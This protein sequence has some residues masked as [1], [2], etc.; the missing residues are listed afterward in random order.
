MFTSVRAKIFGMALLPLM[1][2]LFFMLSAVWEKYQVSSEMDDHDKIAH[3]IINFGGVLHEIQKERGTSG[4]YLTSKGKK[5]A[6]KMDGQR[7]QTDIA[8]EKFKSIISDFDISTLS[9]EAQTSYSHVGPALAELDTLRNNVTAQSVSPAE[10]LSQYSEIN[11]ELIHMVRDVVNIGGNSL[12][13]KT[14]AGY[15]YFIEGKERAGIE[16][17]LLA[18]TFT[19]DKFTGGVYGKF[20]GI[21]SKQDVY[22]QIFHDAATDKQ[23]EVYSNFLIQPDVLATQKLRDI[24]VTKGLSES[25]EAK[26][27]GVEASVWFDAISGKIELLK[28]MEDKIAESLVATSSN[29]KS[30]AFR[31]LFIMLG[32][33]VL[34]TALVSIAVFIIAQGIVLP[35]DHA[36]KMASEVS[37]GNLKGTLENDSRD[38]V[39]HLSRAMNTMVSDLGTTIASVNLVTDELSGSA[40][41]MSSIAEQTLAG[42]VQQQDELQAISIAVSQINNSVSHVSENATTA[43]SAT[44]EANSEVN[45]GLQIVGTTTESI[46]SLAAQIAKITSVIQKLESE[47]S[48]IETVLD[49]IG[50]IA[51][52]TNLLALNAAI[53]AARAGE[54]GRGFAVVADE[55]RTLAGRTQQATQEIQV[56]ISGLQTGAVAA[57]SAME[58]GSQITRQSVEQANSACESL[59]TIASAMTTVVE[60]NEKIATVTEQQKSTMG[61]I[62]QKI[63]S[64]FE[65][66]SDTAR[67]AA[68]SDDSSSK[69]LERAISLKQQ[70]S[71]FSH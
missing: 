8:L 59:N 62:D 49:V 41:E 56:M 43:S 50:S 69:L 14:R 51:E 44:H 12:M 47:T 20:I 21:I 11:E 40:S 24:A 67:G 25:A 36:V 58:Q 63:T 17:A 65:V 71:K 23:K 34:L 6:T 66:A 31:D 30:T 42:V 54:Q 32:L 64:I 60:M 39:G 35:L 52:Q 19:Q 27:L 33:A 22:F 57:V 68:H 28:S 10:S 53:E 18:S 26:G 37:D 38:E 1:T 9:T 15:Y 4:V 55:V 13:N 2:A 3:F 29:L 70:L 61:E 7:A 45:N 16:R 5:F 46:N 48:N